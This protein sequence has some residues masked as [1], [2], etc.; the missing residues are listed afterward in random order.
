M[1]ILIVDNLNYR[2]GN[3]KM[4]R[5]LEGTKIKRQHVSGFRA[6]ITLEYKKPRK[7]GVFLRISFPSSGYALNL[8]VFIFSFPRGWHLWEFPSVYQL[9]N[10]KE[11]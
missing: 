6:R 3:K 5:T 10:G 1:L 7:N 2:K 11:Y 9:Q 8:N 4:R